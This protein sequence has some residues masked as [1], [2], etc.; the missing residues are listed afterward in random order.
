[1]KFE[2][3]LELNVNPEWIEQY[4]DYAKLKKIIY[5]EERE[6]ME[7]RLRQP[8]DLEA[9]NTAKKSD[10][11][12]ECLEHELTKISS[13]Y[14]EV[15]SRLFAELEHVVARCR[16]ERQR[17]AMDASADREAEPSWWD[18]VWATA[19]S[20]PPERQADAA[21][22]TSII[23]H[24]DE[25]HIV[26][27]P[28]SWEAS[29]RQL[30]ST[31]ICS[32]ST[33][34]EEDDAD[35]LIIEARQLF[36][37]LSELERYIQ[38]NRMGFNKI[39]KK[40]DKI[41][42]T[43][44]R[45]WFMEGRVA[46]TVPFVTS[47]AQQLQQAVLRAEIAHAIAAKIT[48]F[49]R[50]RTL[51]RLYLRE[52]ITITRNTVWRDMI[53]HERRISTVNV[54]DDQSEDTHGLLRPVKL[55]GRTW[56]LPARRPTMGLL[57]IIVFI[58]LLNVNL[59]STPPERKCFA[60]LV[61]A[62][63]LWALE[64][65][66]LFVTSMLIPLLIVTLGVLRDDT[67]AVLSAPTATKTVFSYM[68]TSVVML[69]LG[70]F[71]IA[72]AFSKY[73]IA[74]RIAAIVLTKA[75]TRPPIV[76]LANLAVTAFLSMWISN[77]AAPVLC[78]SLLE[79]VLRLLPASSPYGKSLVIGIAL[80]ANVGGMMS[81]ISSPQNM[82]A[83]EIMSPT[84][85][86]GEWFAVA[87]PVACLSLLIIWS[88]LMI[89][90]RP[91]REPPVLVGV[92]QS[93]QTFGWQQY[94]ILFVTLATIA[95]WCANSQIKAYTGDMGVMAAIP[96]VCFFGTGLLTKDDFN[97]FLWTVIMLAMGGIALGQAVSSSGLLHTIARFI[98]ELE[99]G[100]PLWP[101]LA[102]FALLMMIVATL[103]SHTVAAL[104]ILPVVNEVGSKLPDEHS[105]LLVTVC[106]LI[107]SGAMGLPVSGFP[108]MTAVMLEDQVGRNYLSNIDFVKV[109][110]PATILATLVA[111]SVGYG[112]SLA[113]GF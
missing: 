101:V 7:Q 32:V 102:V 17:R 21:Q 24:E 11:F 59:F 9:D 28:L 77:V 43:S 109:G 1:M 78:F 92:R 75:G 36:I 15:E 61:F 33:M 106:V 107:C 72:A 19:P 112:I 3:Q 80:A 99:D 57:C 62:S 60:L 4:I 50:N 94:F 82:I 55:F 37:E 48:D 18:E 69:L 68:F 25:I 85:S 108:N 6:L 41:S 95:L 45:Q 67:G 2:R 56:M 89:V 29:E 51:L 22:S 31:Q 13:F 76:L 46:C 113:L 100:F 87:L 65:I 91:H 81:P 83:L 20:L 79:P 111:V 10:A 63:L 5:K 27:P 105:R 52:H 23:E 98:D 66:P 73:Q 49:Q 88:L 54:E 110:I 86:W 64:V 71:A 58:V 30:S 26:V 90:Y 16:E 38:L 104:V 93:D 39:L 84:L 44:L 53:N 35:L 97:S 34:N 70:G 40:H 47:T 12:R 103:V 14:Q 96:L 74:H 8:T 42:E